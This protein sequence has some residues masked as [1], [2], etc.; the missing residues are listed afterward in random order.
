MDFDNSDQNPIERLWEYRIVFLCLALLLLWALWRHSGSGIVPTASAA[1][2]PV[3]EKEQVDSND[4]LAYGLYSDKMQD[5]LAR[6]QFH[7]LDCA[8]DSVRSLKQRFASGAWK[9]HAIYRATQEPKGHAT[10]G[11]WNIHLKRMERWVKAD[12]TSIT[13]RVAWANAYVSYAWDARGDGY[14]NS[15]SANGW[16][17]F[18]QRMARAQEILQEASILPS[19]C[20]EW[21]VVMLEI[22]KAE[23]WNREKESALF[24]EAIA[25][26]PGYYY[27]Y[28]AQM[29]YLQ[30]KWHGEEGEAEAFA[31]QAANQAGEAQGDALYFQIAAGV[32]CG[33]DADTQLR[34]LSWPR[35]QKGYAEIEKQF[36]PSLANMNML[37]YM[38]VQMEDSAVA[39]ELFPKIGERWDEMVWKKKTYF[40]S[41]K[42]WAETTGPFFAQQRARV[43]AAEAEL[44]TEAGRQY[45]KDFEQRFAPY[46]KQCVQDSTADLSKFEV[47][48]QV[49]ES[50]EIKHLGTS[51]MTQVSVCVL[52]HRVND[53]APPPHAPFWIHLEIDPRTVLKV[54]MN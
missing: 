22:A 42:H 12:P 32:V 30:P 39:Y 54:S 41:C 29:S 28:R 43:T 3:A 26:E 17:L 33:C 40:D 50:G 47:T 13:A 2:C 49:G 8:A 15:V 48:V 10:E 18:N 16:R 24:R 45:V 38:A 34:K 1:A 7:D 52:Q 6:E 36:G 35:I 11:D 25:A 46:V 9:L 21:Y 51:P 5:L 53:V 19:K 27:F 23:G 20:P 4:I 44:Q 31:E 37:A 14:A